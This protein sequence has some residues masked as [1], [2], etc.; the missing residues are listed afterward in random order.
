MYIGNARTG[1]AVK[2]NACFSDEGFRGNWVID[3]LVFYIFD[4]F[5]Q[6]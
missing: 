2:Y 5:L 3:I 1:I 6:L 4:I